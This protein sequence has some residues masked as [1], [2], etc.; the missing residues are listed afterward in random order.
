[1]TPG[2]HQVLAGAAPRDAITTHALLAR[3]AIRSMGIRSEIFCDA[4][5]LAGELTQR[6]RPHTAW[7]KHT[8]EG[9]RAVLHYSIDSDAFEYVHERAE[10]TAL[11]YHNVTPP[12]L[13][14]R[15]A[16]ALALQCAHGRQ[17]LASFAGRVAAAAADSA[18]NA[19]ELA[20]V[21]IPNADVIGVLRDTPEARPRSVRV[22]AQLPVKL[23]FVGRGV[24][25]KCQHDLILTTAALIQQGTPAELT[26]VGSWGGNRAY[27]ERCR[28]L[29]RVLGIED[30]VRFLGSV[31]DDVLD[32]AY[33]DA[34]VFLCLSEHEGYCVPLLEAMDRQLPI[35]AFAAG[36]VP[37]T[38]G[39]AGLLL[40]DK[41]PSLTAEA[42]LSIVRDTSLQEEMVVLS[43]Q[44]LAAHSP[45]AVGRRLAGFIKEFA[46]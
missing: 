35:V 23:L 43:A 36:A 44:Q 7:Q 27:L 41:S 5:H 32:Q 45:S 15:D 11:H 38:L 40:A 6:I 24:P 1:M 13:L 8:R 29:T 30:H 20:D 26:L 37:E 42:V 16:P 14:W 12:D 39:R 3:E 34:D 46:S 22:A 21:G 25:N 17:R 28:H 2:V 9:D 10:R 31:D 33:R 18:F 19:T 4:R